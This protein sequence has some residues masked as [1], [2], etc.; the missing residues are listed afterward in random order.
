MSRCRNCYIVFFYR[1]IKGITTI[2]PILK[3]LFS[4]VHIHVPETVSSKPSLVYTTSAFDLKCP[5][6]PRF[7]EAF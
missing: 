6:L 4:V 1:N 2:L 5:L 3:T 7:T